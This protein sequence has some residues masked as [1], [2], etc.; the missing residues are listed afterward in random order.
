[1]I[2]QSVNNEILMQLK[3]GRVSSICRDI[4][5][6]GT[7]G[8]R[9]LLH[10]EK[11]WRLSFLGRWYGILYFVPLVLIA[12]SRLGFMASVAEGFST[13]IVL[14]SCLLL[15]STIASIIDRAFAPRRPSIERHPFHVRHHV[16]IE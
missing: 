8:G 2:G 12:V 3:N 15:L 14:L 7:G 5:Y 4:W 13:L 11:R 6:V 10:R 16:E 1:M 9:N